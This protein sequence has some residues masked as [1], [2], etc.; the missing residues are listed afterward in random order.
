MQLLL[1][2]LLAF[3]FQGVSGTVGASCNSGC[4][5]SGETCHTDG[6]NV[7]TCKTGYTSDGGNGCTPC[8]TGTYKSAIGDGGCTSCGSQETTSS[9]G[10]TASSACVCVAGYYLSGS[11]CTACGAGTYKSAIGDAAESCVSAPSGWYAVDSS[12]NA[13]SSPYTGAVGISQA[14]TGNYV[15]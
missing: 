10:N 9:T 12:N 3:T 2:V 14:G 4:S 8:G 1:L 5:G 6:T 15:V 7:C 11:T 13:L